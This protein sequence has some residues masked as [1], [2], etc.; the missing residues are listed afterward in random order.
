VERH[1]LPTLIGKA[2]LF[3]AV[4]QTRLTGCGGD[5]YAAGSVPAGGTAT[6]GG[7]GTTGGSAL[8]GGTGALGGASAAGGAST[9][10]GVA[11]NGG[12]ATGGSRPLSVGCSGTV[13]FPDPAVDTAVRQALSIP[14]GPLDGSAIAT[15]TR[16]SLTGAAS[17]DGLE[18]AAALT[19][20]TT[21]GGQISDLQR[22]AGLTQLWRIIILDNELMDLSPL[23]N[24]T[25]LSY[26][27]VRGNRIASVDGS[28]L[29]AQPTPDCAFLDL[30]DN[31]LVAGSFEAGVQAFC[32]KS[33][34]V[35]WGG[36]DTETGAC[37]DCR[38]PS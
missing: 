28:E 21:D 37:M 38:M 32:A 1:S 11:A 20:L 27:D 12:D 15:L 16:L 36:T 17:L 29:A 4:V 8:S 14:T 19:S 13:N 33:W 6:T 30:R 31:P 34:S 10:G 22:L 24:L 7:E 35:V 25:A 3:L 5:T 26:L 2:G 18:C 23:R 9:V